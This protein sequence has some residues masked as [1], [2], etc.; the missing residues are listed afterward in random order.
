MPYQPFVTVDDNNQ[1]EAGKR[2]GSVWVI[3]PNDASAEKAKSLN[4]PT[5]EKESSKAVKQQLE[6]SAE[7]RKIN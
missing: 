2:T 3:S 6:M 5:S 4:S 7:E 1:K